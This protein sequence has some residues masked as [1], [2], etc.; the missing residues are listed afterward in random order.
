[1]SFFP[2]ILYYYEI[3]I[4]GIYWFTVFYYIKYNLCILTGV[5]CIS[6][7]IWMIYK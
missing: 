6:F 4:I 3:Q 2:I 7:D 5:P 1:M